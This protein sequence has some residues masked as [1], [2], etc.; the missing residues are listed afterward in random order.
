MNKYNFPAFVTLLATGPLTV[1]AANLA[2]PF[3]PIISTAQTVGQGDWFQMGAGGTA[4]QVIDINSGGSLIIDGASFGVIIGQNS[5]GP[6]NTEKTWT[7]NVNPGGSIVRNVASGDGNFIV[8]NRPNTG[9]I[10]NINGGTW[11]G[12][13]HSAIVI[14]REGGTG[15]INFIDGQVSWAVIPTF[16]AAGGGFGPGDG[17]INFTAGSTAS[18]TVSTADVSTYE[19][20]W[21]AGDL[22]YDGGNVGN[23]GDYFVVTG[24]TLSV[25]LATTLDWDPGDTETGGAGNWDLVSNNWQAA[26]NTSPNQLWTPNTGIQT[27][28]FGGT[29]GVV[30]LVDDIVADVITVTAPGYELTGP[31]SLSANGISTTSDLT[32]SAPLGG[33]LPL[34]KS[35]SATVTLTADSTAYTDEITVASGTLEITGQLGGAV[36]V[37]DGATLS[38]EGLVA[39]SLTLGDSLGA[40]LLLDPTTEPGALTVSSLALNGTATVLVPSDLAV[41]IYTIVNYGSFA[42]GTAADF[43]VVGVL[44]RITIN[45]TGSSITL[46]YDGVQDI[47][48]INSSGSGFWSVGG[49]LFDSN[50]TSTDGYFSNGDSVR[51]D[52][53]APGGVSLD[54]SQGEIAPAL[55]TFENSIGSDYDFSGSPITGLGS[56]VL[57][58]NGVD[59]GG[60]VIFNQE[61]S[62][63]GGTTVNRG[64]LTL[65]D[66]NGNSVGVVRGSLTVNQGGIVILEGSNTMGWGS[67]TRVTELNLFDG[68]LLEHQG[69]GDSMWGLSVNLRGSAMTTENG[70]GVG[71]GVARF[72]LGGGSEVNVLAAADPSVIGGLIRV[73]QA[74]L[75]FNI[76]DGPAEIDLRVTA[77]LEPQI[78]NSMVKNGSGLMLISGSNGISG[79]TT[80]NEGC[81]IVDDADSL[82]ALNTVTVADGAGFGG[83]VGAGNLND[84]DISAVA[85]EVLWDGNGQASL[86][87]DTNGSDATVG[88]NI[89]GNFNLLKKGLGGMARP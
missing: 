32:V 43:E 84:S 14:G 53:T 63:E 75:P 9:G 28:A 22:Q 89:V 60:N 61:N 54:N 31:A 70:I 12:S 64:T 42:S 25:N 69:I 67:G 66:P 2:D 79:A 48:W 21:N 78:G 35:G 11:D 44:G 5:P 45:D 8:G 80:V 72:S 77:A 68:A 65:N 46:T 7:L 51:F 74:D 39:G 6:G 30:T 73:R 34:S 24:E 26:P 33:T 86:V 83:I 23:F 29:G 1:T 19:G 18:L 58:G 87:I 85:S 56:V 57:N 17:A 82:P 49:D 27:A 3:G 15:R 47:T 81:L 50:W 40:S 52:D 13:Q 10:V 59:S 55:V 16:D 76:A 88:S 37:S 36:T 71:S 41:G 38:G 62:Y 4:N 20:W